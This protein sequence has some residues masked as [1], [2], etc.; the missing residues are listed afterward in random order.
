MSDDNEKD[1]QDLINKYTQQQNAFQPN[2]AFEGKVSQGIDPH[3]GIDNQGFVNESV[4]VTPGS[5]AT[6]GPDPVPVGNTC[7]QCDMMHP[8][9]QSGEKCPNA[10]AKSLR[11]ESDDPTLDVNKYLTT[12]QTILMS[13]ISKKKIKDIKKFYQNITIEMTKFLEEYTE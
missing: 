2:P 8:P 9:L 13:Q 4:P 5:I 11:E 6:K 7:Q 10:M 12:L 1:I 3:K